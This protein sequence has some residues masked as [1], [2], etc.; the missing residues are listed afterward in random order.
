MKISVPG[1]AGHCDLQYLGHEDVYFSFE[2]GKRRKKIF[3][4][5]GLEDTNFPQ[6]EFGST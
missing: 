6:H 5:S 4:L 1:A 3:K 2:D